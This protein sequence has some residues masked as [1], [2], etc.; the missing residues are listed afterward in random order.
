MFEYLV[1]ATVF[2]LCGWKSETLVAPDR[3]RDKATLQQAFLDHLDT[4][5]AAI[6]PAAGSSR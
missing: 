1:A 6:H 5:Q 3:E 4:L 2:C